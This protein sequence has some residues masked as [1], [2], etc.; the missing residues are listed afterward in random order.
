[1]R[2]KN[3]GKHIWNHK[4]ELVGHSDGSLLS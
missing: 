1:M 2:I 3:F 4:N